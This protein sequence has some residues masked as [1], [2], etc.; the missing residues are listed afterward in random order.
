MAVPRRKSFKPG[1]QPTR[2]SLSRPQGVAL[3]SALKMLLKLDDRTM[4]WVMFLLWFGGRAIF[5][6]KSVAAFASFATV[7]I[8]RLPTNI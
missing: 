3:S 8:H 5:Y 6:S 1:L 4:M 2:F 7:V